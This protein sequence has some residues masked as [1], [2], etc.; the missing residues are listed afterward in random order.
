MKRAAVLIGVSRAGNLPVLADAIPSV[1]AMEAWALAQ[2]LDRDLVKVITDEAGPVGLQPIK[3][4]VNDIVGRATVEQLVV[5]FAGHGVNIG[6]YEYWLLSEAPNDPQAAVNVDGSV[7]LARRCSVPHVIF[8]SDACRTPAAGLQSQRVTGGELFPNEAGGGVARTETTVDNFFACALGDPAYELKQPSTDGDAYRS[9]YTLCLTEALQG[10]PPTPVDEDYLEGQ[11]CGLV[12]VRRL[13]DHLRTAVA[14]AISASPS[15]GQ[16]WQIPDARLTSDEKAWIARIGGPATPSAAPAPPSTVETDTVE[17]Y[18][19]ETHTVEMHQAALRQELTAPTTD[20]S[21][22]VAKGVDARVYLDG[23]SFPPSPAAPDRTFKVRG[24]KVIRA[25]AAGGAQVSA[26]GDQVSALDPARLPAST[27]L[28]F[29]NGTSV[30][31]PAFGDLVG[32]LTFADGEL[33]SVAYEPCDDTDRRRTYQGRVNEVERLRSLIMASA[34]SGALQL[35][36]DLA[37]VLCRPLPDATRVDPT[38]AVYVAYA[39]RDL[40]RR[41]AMRALQDAV[42]DDLT[43]DLFDLA[44]LAGDIGDRAIAAVGPVVPFVPILSRGW[45]LLGAYRVALP[46]PVLALRGS[47]VPSLY[48]VFDQSATPVL[49]T[50][51]EESV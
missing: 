16:I 24:A 45:G 50:L 3:D 17:A 7:T 22:L 51:M 47:L 27:L 37:E 12:R 18:A 43:V 10:L 34:K 5:Y 1:R 39:Y 26:D 46:E 41:S 44:L 25:L 30:V 23:S 36:D 20:L 48:T 21:G 15:A 35:D 49:T 14:Q 38:I 42:R 2:G 8:F 9:I 40:Q 33:V 13:K 31:L 11:T 32:A 6:Y 28:T 4:A 19:V 29:D